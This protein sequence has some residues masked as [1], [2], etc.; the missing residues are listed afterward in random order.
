[1][2]ESESKNYDRIFFKTKNFG[3]NSNTIIWAEGQIFMKHWVFDYFGGFMPWRCGA[4]TEFIIRVDQFINVEKINIILFKRRIHDSN[5]IVQKKTK[6]NS[7]LRK[8]HSTYINK[9]SKNINNINDA[10]IIKIINNYYEIF[11]HSKI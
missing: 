6:Y 9:I 5:L 10:V 2:K 4:D 7:K 8:L 1:M 3:K 11:P